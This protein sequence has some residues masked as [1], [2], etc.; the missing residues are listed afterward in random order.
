MKRKF[1]Q[2]LF[3]Q[4]GAFIDLFFFQDYLSNA[5]FILCFKLFCDAMIIKRYTIIFCC[6]NVTLYHL[7]NIAGEGGYTFYRSYLYFKNLFLM[8]FLYYYLF[9]YNITY[10]LNITL[11][12]MLLKMQSIILFIKYD[13]IFFKWYRKKK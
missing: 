3:H 5:T 12:I 13:I 2:W 4:K 10:Y 8:L 9:I 7:N 6:K 11:A 1:K